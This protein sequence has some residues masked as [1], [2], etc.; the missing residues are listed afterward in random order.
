VATRFGAL[1]FNTFAGGFSPSL[2]LFVR[3]SILSTVLTAGFE[4]S[5]NRSNRG[6]LQYPSVGDTAE[7]AVGSELGRV[8]SQLTQR[9]MNIQPTIKIPVGFKFNVRVD[10]DIAFDEPYRQIL[11]N[12]RQH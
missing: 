8:G 5:Q 10:R 12:S 7:G 9:Q 11:T 4:L 6:I 2:T 3:Y 1:D